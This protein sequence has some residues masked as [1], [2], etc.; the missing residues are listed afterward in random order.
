MQDQQVAKRPLVVV[1]HTKL[2]D[3]HRLHDQLP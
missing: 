2:P 1:P 3:A